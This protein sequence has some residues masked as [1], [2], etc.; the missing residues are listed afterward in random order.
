M[1][2]FLEHPSSINKEAK[3]IADTQVLHRPLIYDFKFFAELDMHSSEAARKDIEHKISP[4]IW[5]I[6]LST[7]IHM[8]HVCYF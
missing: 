8:I 2:N 3:D 6:L 5:V 1:L 4:S 7:P